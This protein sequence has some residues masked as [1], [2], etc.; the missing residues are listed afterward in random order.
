MYERSNGAVAD[1]YD[2]VAGPFYDTDG[3]VSILGI[4][5]HA[6]AERVAAGTIIGCQLA[7]ARRTWMYPVWQFTDG[8]QPIGHLD[9]VWTI[10]REAADAWTAALWLRTRNQALGGATAVDYLRDGRDPAVVLD[11]AHADA[12]RWSV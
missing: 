3:V 9:E 8:N 1:A 5:E 2:Q 10:L 11:E 7:D 6:V 12:A 4:S